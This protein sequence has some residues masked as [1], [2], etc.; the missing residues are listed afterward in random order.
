MSSTDR[1]PR[2]VLITGASTGIGQ[3]CALRLA[4][5]GWRV[6]AGVRRGEDGDALVSKAGRAIKPLLLDVT[7]PDPIASAVE[8]VGA[9][10]SWG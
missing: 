2:N 5:R 6:F 4:T 10:V 3:A 7:C 1:L 9:F 8:I